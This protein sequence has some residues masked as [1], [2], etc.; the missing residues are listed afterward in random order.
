MNQSLPFSLPNDS[1]AGFVV[2]SEA[3]TKHFSVCKIRMPRLNAFTLERRRGRV[4]RKA[5]ARG[6][7]CA[8]RSRCRL[9]KNLFGSGKDNITYVGRPS[10]C[11]NCGALV[12]SGEKTCTQCDAPLVGGQSPSQLDQPSQNESGG[13]S[14]GADAV[15][16]A[17]A[18][19]TRPAT[20]TFIFL[21]ANVFMFLLVALSAGGTNEATFNGELIAYGAKLNALIR[22]GEWWR[23]VTPIFLHGNW[24]HLLMNMYGLWILG[25]YVEKLYGSAKFVVFW[26]LTGIAGVV[27]SYLT[28]RPDM[29]IG[30][31]SRFLFRAEDA[32]SVGASGALFGLIGVLFVFGIKFR[33]ELPEE[34]KRAFG[35]G[36][37]PTILINVVIGYI[38]P[39]ID[40]S[41]HM[42]GLFAGAALALVVGY[43]RPHQSASMSIVW[44]ILQAAALALVAVSFLMIA[45]HFHGSPPKFNVAAVKNA[46][47]P[48]LK[49][50][51]LEKFINAINAGQEAFFKAVNNK[52]TGEVEKAVKALDS[53]P[54]LDDQA[55]EVRNELKTL[56]AHASDYAKA[57]KPADKKAERTAFEE[58]NKIALEYKAWDEKLKGWVS[59]AGVKYGLT[60]KQS[61]EAE[62]SSDKK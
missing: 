21:I 6:F 17:R 41:A 13:G 34:F 7:V 11:R 18:V 59:T 20:F 38:F 29:H 16:F 15:R 23:F 36:M 47:L 26:V 53:A 2:E 5:A 37:L 10:V 56:L 60:L 9:L 1:I 12:A 49:T 40:N 27:A 22:Q 25:P 50:N 46:V 14:S 4:Q 19:L 31:V 54:R 42:G 55:N 3:S 52:D 44:Q 24:T 48:S 45:R 39:F 62:D 30:P 57:P 8:K 28:V 58:Q 61:P 32:A 33:H 35:A 43:K 51:E